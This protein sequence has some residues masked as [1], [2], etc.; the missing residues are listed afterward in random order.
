MIFLNEVYKFS[1]NIFWQN[2]YFIFWFQKIRFVNQNMQDT[3]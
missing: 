3:E 1:F 2:V